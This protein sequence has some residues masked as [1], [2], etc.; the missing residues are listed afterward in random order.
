MLL[1]QKSRAVG[2]A[3]GLFVSREGHDDIAFRH[4]SFPLQTDQGLRERGVAI[5]HVDR[6][7]AVE[8]AVLVREYERVDGPVLWVGFHDIEMTQKQNRFSGMPAAV[9]D[10]E[11]AFRRVIFGGEKCHVSRRESRAEHPFLNGLGCRGGTVSMRGVDLDQSLQHVA[12]KLLVGGGRHG[13]RGN[14]AGGLYPA[15]HQDGEQSNGW[16]VHG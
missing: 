2:I 15:Q 11:V 14:D 6:A 3:T 16:L 1:E 8:P 12:R 7:A 4:E 9:S 10:D 13:R 5:L